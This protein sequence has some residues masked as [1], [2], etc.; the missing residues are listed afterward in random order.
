MVEAEKTFSIGERKARIRKTVLSARNMLSPDDRS[1]RSRRIVTGVVALEAFRQASTVMGYCSFGSE[2]ETDGFTETAL[3][4]GK[5]LV[6]PRIDRALGC[7]RLYLV[8]DPANQLLDGVWGIREPD[9][10]RCDE[11]APGK[12]EF[13]LS[14]GVA[15]DQLGGRIGYG[16]GYY[17]RL[18]E[19]CSAQGGKFAIVAGA[20]DHQVVPFVPVE[21]H[22]VPI[23]T[24]VT[25]SRQIGCQR[26]ASTNF[27]PVPR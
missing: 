19:S 24:I 13:V 8:N 16:K 20:F 4:Q 9:P 23:D 18:L 15:F 17:D 27:E 22:D 3:A 14:P 7:L 26:G 11:L 12:L 21:P 1:E 10:A 25:E 2:V 6:L 5:N